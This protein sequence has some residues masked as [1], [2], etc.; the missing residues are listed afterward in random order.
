MSAEDRDEIIALFERVFHH[1]MSTAL[2]DWKYGQGRGS[3]VVARRNGSIVAHYG[4][5]QRNL[6]NN[7]RG[8]ASVQCV[9]TMVDPD[10]RGT[11][12]RHGPYFL[13]AQAFLDRYVGY[14][15]RYE[16]GFGFP[17]SRVMRLGEKV[18]IQAAVDEIVEPVW[19]AS[20]RSQCT[21]RRLSLSLPT[22]AAEIDEHWKN[23]RGCMKNSIIG[24]RDSSYLYYRY[25]LNPTYEY[26]V[27][28]VSSPVQTRNLGVLVLRQEGARLIL[29]DII[30]HVSDFSTMLQYARSLLPSHGCKE[31][32][33]WITESHLS[34]LNHDTRRIDRPDVRIPTSVCTNGPKPEEL[35]GRW[36]LTAGDAEFK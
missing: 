35:R 36:W 14:G 2:W 17:N 12:S 23:M 9:D 21:D 28:L 16:F 15:R 1:P 3:A 6:L 5:V 32:I 7:G 18:G 4:G 26:E 13:V 31:L 11:L 30:G 24:C 29:L 10:E 34:L 25:L 20:P 19:E 8:Q 33:T 22:D 27:L